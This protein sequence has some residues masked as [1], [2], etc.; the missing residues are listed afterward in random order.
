MEHVSLEK[1]SI[2]D[3]IGFPEK[4]NAVENRVRSTCQKILERHKGENILFVG[5]GLSV[6][7]V[8]SLKHCASSEVYKLASTSS[9][10]LS[11]AF[12]V[13]APHGSDRYVA[14]SQNKGIDI[15]WHIRFAV[16]LVF[17]QELITLSVSWVH[18][19]C[20]NVVK[21]S[22]GQSSLYPMLMSQ[23]ECSLD[24]HA[25]MASII[26]GNCKQALSN[27]Q[28]LRTSPFIRL[29]ALA[30]MWFLFVEEW[31]TTTWYSRR[32]QRNSEFVSE[33]GWTKC[34]ALQLLTLLA[35]ESE[36]DN[37]PYCSLTE[38]IRLKDSEKWEVI[39]LWDDGH[40]RDRQSEE[41]L[42]SQI[43]SWKEDWAYSEFNWWVTL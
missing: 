21:I 23:D 41:D 31:L 28:T 38:C 7:Y 6:H 35:D 33:L 2:W 27:F 34:V 10:V 14:K 30:E 4:R 37:I 9:Q 29:C 42:K 12:S 36:M 43:E 39:G 15:L 18:T 32:R 17:L 20:L 22:W 5:H 26:F 1:C 13:K 16:P 40:I 24:W 19:F 25:Q 3:K 11:E 8:V